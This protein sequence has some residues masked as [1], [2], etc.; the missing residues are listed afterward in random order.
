MS[1]PVQTLLV[2]A[3]SLERAGRVAEAIEAY[4][5]LLAQVPGLPDSWY[6]LALLQKKLGGFD[7]ALSSYQEALNRGISQPEEV[8]L[9]RAVIFSDCL[10][11]E[12]AAESALRK[13][14]ELNPRYLPAL[15]NLANLYEDVGRREDALAQYEALLTIAPNHCEALARYVTLKGVTGLDDP[16]VKRLKS[17]IT[18]SGANAMDKASLGFAL[19]KVLDAC[20]AFDQAFS[21]YVRANQSSRA[22]AQT[23]SRGPLYDRQSHERFIDQLIQTFASPSPHP[24]MPRAGSSPCPIFICGMFRSGSTL[25][26][27]ILAGHPKMRAGG[28]IDFIPALVRDELAPF[29]ASIAHISAP[30][31]E[32]IALRYRDRLSSMF[33]GAS[34]ITDKRP[35]NF[36]YI[37]LIK[38][39]FPNAKIIHTKRDALDNCLSIYF[40]HLGHGM[41]YALDLMDIGHYYQQYQRLMTHWQQLYGA[42]ILTL[43]YDTLV[44]E[45][46]PAIETLLDFVGL[47]WDDNCLHF[48]HVKNA[49]KTASVWQVREGLYQR[50]SGRWR[51][52]AHHLAPL[53]EYLAV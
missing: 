53:R 13:A 1:T 31:L 30:Q 37:G 5:G 39:L 41:G 21:A 8:H 35:D 50:S 6:N 29:P 47:D 4:Q 24:A 33:P 38:R 15:L 22:G 48:Q 43:E 27:Q 18:H 25:A 32:Q 9:N 3:A 26:E 16:L 19:G 46:R 42:D 7:A 52:Y 40:L 51:N 28:E 36:L 34:H 23:G 12:A 14:L 17:A 49:V 11:Q 45:P 44:H 10:R 20:G 2:K